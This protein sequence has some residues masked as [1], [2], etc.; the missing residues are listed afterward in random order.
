MAVGTAASLCIHLVGAGPGDPDLLTVKAWKLIRDAEVIVHDCLV[1]R[2]VLD[3]IPNHA[4]LIDVGKM[5]GHHPFPQDKINEMLVD[6]ARSGRR[7]VRLKGGDPFIFGRGGEEADYLARHGIA[8]EI[9]PGITAASACAS[10]LGIPLTHRGLATGVRF[11]TGHCQSEELDHDWQG[12]ADPNTTLAVYMGLA[13]I[14]KI[15]DRL[16]GA[17]LPGST[18]VAVICDGTLPHQTHLIA[19]LATIGDLAA[20]LNRTGRALFVI[21]QVVNLAPAAKLMEKEAALA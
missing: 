5:P 12:L 6:L 3:G 2:A 11:I 14:R 20:M 18:L 4:T 7:V 8:C 10:A 13:N 1:S 16:I 9:V 15:A 21:G 17:G 19:S